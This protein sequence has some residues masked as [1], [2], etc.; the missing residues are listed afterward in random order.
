MADKTILTIGEA[1]KRGIGLSW[2]SPG[3]VGL[4]VLTEVGA[5]ILSVGLQIALALFLFRDALRGLEVVVSPLVGV[6]TAVAPSFDLAATAQWL[7]PL[8]AAALTAWIIVLVLRAIW[9]GAGVGRFADR[10]SAAGQRTPLLKLAADNLAR[11]VLVALVFAPIALSGFFIGA[12]LVGAS[13]VVALSLS[14]STLSRLFSA[15]LVAFALTL[16]LLV[17]RGVDLLFRVALVRSVAAA[18]G[19]LDAL[20]QGLGLLWARLGSFIALAL[21]FVFL[22]SMALSSSS[23]FASALQSMPANGGAATVLFGLVGLGTALVGAILVSFLTTAEYAAYTALD[24]DARGALPRP[25]TASPR[26]KT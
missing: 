19:P 18:L 14:S 23:A 12:T 21:I 4:G 20:V 13:G 8:L 5:I 9:L 25:E 1:L 17:S 16:A 10:L 6:P 11:V 26:E 7:I 15:L 2:S 22:Q 24:L 3:V